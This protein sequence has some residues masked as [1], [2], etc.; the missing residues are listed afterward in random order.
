MPNFSASC[1]DSIEICP[2]IPMRNFTSCWGP[3]RIRM[4]SVLMM[5]LATHHL[6]WWVWKGQE[7]NISLFMVMRITQISS[8]HSS[9]DT[10]S[11]LTCMGLG[12]C[13]ARMTIISIFSSNFWFFSPFVPVTASIAVQFAGTVI[14]QLSSC[15]P[16]SFSDLVSLYYAFFLSWQAAS[17][18]VPN[19]LQRIPFPLL[20]L[21]FLLANFNC[22]SIAPQ[23][24][25]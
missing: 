1:C 25:Q 24:C 7:V 5:A 23:S 22:S 10:I 8:S 17:R 20:F 6:F 12:E 16:F 3:T 14:T 13:G 21:I 9:G 11:F 19:T 18:Q 4:Y 2:P 15:L